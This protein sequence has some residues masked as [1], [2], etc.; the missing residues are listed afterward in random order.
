MNGP[1]LRGLLK[2]TGL[3]CFGNWGITGGLGLD[4]SRTAVRWE[5]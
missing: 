2:D 5:R 1:Q 3:E 4:C